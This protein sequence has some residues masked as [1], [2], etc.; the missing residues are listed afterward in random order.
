MRYEMKG[1]ENNILKLNKALYGLKQA[2]MTWNNHINGYLLKNGFVKCPYEYAIYIKIKE[3]G[4]T[5]IVCLYID[6]L[7]FI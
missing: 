3:S 6:D 5:L 4:G 2:P 7:I 1:H